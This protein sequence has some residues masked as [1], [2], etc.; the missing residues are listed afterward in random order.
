MARAEERIVYF[1]LAETVEPIMIVRDGDPMAGGLMTDVVKLVFENS[2]YVIEPRVLPWQRMRT[3]LERSE[4]WIVHGIPGSFDEEVAY[5]LSELPIFPF[6]HVAVTMKGSGIDIKSIGDLNNRSLILIE[7]FHYAGLDD[8]LALANADN[9]DSNIGVLR[10]F[11]PRGSLD[12]LRHGR[13]DIVIEWQA[14]V[15]YNLKAAG[16]NFDD[17]DFHD[18]TSIV[19]TEN[20]YLAFS[21]RQSDEFRTF[22]N[23]RIRALTDS[24]RLPELVRKYYDPAT[25][26]EF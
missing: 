5:E 22:V 9:G 14:R 25:P 24:G 16:L 13:G 15:I 17:V 8:H 11:S 1:I 7:N 2:D 26:P 3:E 4:D 10:S 23:G 12:M 18:A 20:V 6:N 21:A 19:P